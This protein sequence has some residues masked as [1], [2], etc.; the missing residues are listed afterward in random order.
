METR[1]KSKPE[2]ISQRAQRNAG[3]I[4]QVPN[5]VIQ[6]IGTAARRGKLIGWRRY[7][8]RTVFS[9]GETHGWVLLTALLVLL[10]ARGNGRGACAVFRTKA[11]EA[12]PAATSG[13]GNTQQQEPERAHKTSGS[14]QAGREADRA[15]S[16][17]S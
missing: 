6:I 5:G 4:L 11:I 2:R 9:T 1:K 8:G 7:A 10:G 17:P 15:G 12:S 13:I 16:I 3:P 14:G